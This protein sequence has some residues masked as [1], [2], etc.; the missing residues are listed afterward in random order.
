M[1]DSAGRA[2]IEA[3]ASKDADFSNDKTMR[4]DLIDGFQSHSA[5]RDTPTCHPRQS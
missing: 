3:E 5:A 1:P 2:G 4:A